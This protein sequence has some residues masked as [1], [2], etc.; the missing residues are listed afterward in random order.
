MVPLVE[1]GVQV[2]VE[3]GADIDAANEAGFTPLH[4]AAF[5]ASNEVIEYLVARGADID[6]QQHEGQTAFRL[7]E[8]SAAGGFM[9]HT[10]PETAALLAALGADTTLGVDG[11]TLARRRDVALAPGNQE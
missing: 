3:A 7:A 8:G 4:G 2:L 5:I 6:A 9:W 10:Y 1:E 11:E